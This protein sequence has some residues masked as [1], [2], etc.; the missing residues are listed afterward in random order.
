M[1]KMDISYLL[2][3]QEFRKKAA[4]N[5]FAA[6]LWSWSDQQHLSLHFQKKEDKLI[7]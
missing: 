2:M 5:L 3:L 6:F 1:N 4:G 7:D